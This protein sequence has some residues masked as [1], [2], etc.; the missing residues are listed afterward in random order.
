MKRGGVGCPP[1]APVGRAI[2]YDFPE[3]NQRNF[4]ITEGFREEFS[5]PIGSFWMGKDSKNS[6]CDSPAPVGERTSRQK[7][8]DREIRNKLVHLSPA[9]AAANFCAS[10]WATRCTRCRS[11]FLS[12]SSWRRFFFDLILW[13][14][15]TEH[16]AT[17]AL[18][19]RGAGLIATALAAI[20]SWVD[21][22]GDQRIRDLGDAWQHTIGNDPGARPTAQLLQALSLR[23]ER[24]RAARAGPLPYCGLH[25]AVHGLEGEEWYSARPYRYDEAQR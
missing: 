8:E 5:N 15:G 16:W 13:Q 14:A 1:L 23:D 22:L 20:V 19:C 21:F 3:P 9:N 6:I 2:A 18:W 7:P 4:R 24:G 17:N 25:Y 12:G 11:R 10:L